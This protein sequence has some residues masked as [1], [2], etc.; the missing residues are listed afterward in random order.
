VRRH[1]S[2]P[3]NLHA[4]LP[5]AKHRGIQ[6]SS[7]TRI[8]RKTIFSNHAFQKIAYQRRIDKSK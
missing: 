1:V 5:C 2:L 7:G 6:T 3:S 4:L 8:A